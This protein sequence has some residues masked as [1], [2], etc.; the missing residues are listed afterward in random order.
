MLLY[1]APIMSVKNPVSDIIVYP[2]PAADVVRVSGVPGNMNLQLFSISGQKIYEQNSNEM[3]L[4][5]FATGTYILK[6]N[7]ENESYSQV[8]IISRP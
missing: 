8:L 1:D 6:I 5:L 4:K 3:N 2:N 7:A